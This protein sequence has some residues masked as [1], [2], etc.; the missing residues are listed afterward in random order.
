[1]NAISQKSI[2]ISLFKLVLPLLVLLF[3]QAAANAQSYTP[4]EQN[5]YSLVQGKVAYDQAGSK[6]WNEA[7]VRNLCQGTTNA[8]QTIKC[9]STKIS[10]GVAWNMASSA[11]SPSAL[12]S[13]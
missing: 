6:T 8:T 10:A 5:C 11:C 2:S 4:E 7:N 13:T 3:I 1:M 12:N 9:F